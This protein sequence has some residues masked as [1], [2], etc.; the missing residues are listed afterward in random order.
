M[1]IPA[2][3]IQKVDSTLGT[4]G[5]PYRI[6][7]DG[8]WID[9][10]CVAW[11]IPHEEPKPFPEF[12][13][14]LED[15]FSR[16]GE[17]LLK[18]QIRDIDEYISRIRELL[19][20]EPVHIQEELAELAP[21]IKEAVSSHPFSGSGQRIDSL[22]RKVRELLLKDPVTAYKGNLSWL[23]I[24]LTTSDCIVVA[25]TTDQFGILRFE[26]TDGINYDLLTEDIIEQLKTLDEKYGIDIVGASCGSVEFILKRI[27]KGKEASELGE[28]LLDF[29]PDI[30]EAPESFPK[31]RVALWWD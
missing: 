5:Q 30:Y 19:S 12:S 6:L 15:A 21:R 4:T 13:Q 11:S 3:V 28:W 8:E 26:R 10:G 9:T 24:T 31:G 1:T 14:D 16:I 27:P 29:C 22:L 17:L 18:E 23:D 25:P 2:D 20:K 7:I